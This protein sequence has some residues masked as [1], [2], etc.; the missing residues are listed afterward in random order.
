MLTGD[1]LYD[2]SATGTES[3]SRP[4]DWLDL[5]FDNSSTI[6]PLTRNW[7][8]CLLRSPVFCGAD[9]PPFF[10]EA[11]AWL[12]ERLG[13]NVQVMPGDHGVT[14]R[15]AQRGGQGHPCLQR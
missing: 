4:T 15:D 11:A 9:S 6:V 2:G 7:P 3:G 8:G 12:A 13:T 10:R 14:L 1:T 5:E